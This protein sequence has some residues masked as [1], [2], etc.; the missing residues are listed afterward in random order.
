MGASEKIRWRRM[1]NEM[2][3]LHSEKELIEQTN[4]EAAK[5]FQEH[6]VRFAAQHGLD[7]K[8]LNKQ[9]EE[10]LEEV[11]G[12]D[13]PKISPENFPD[14]EDPPPGALVVC[15]Q[16]MEPETEYAEMQ[17]NTEVHDSFNKLFR[18]LAM[19]LHPDKMVASVT[20]EQG[21]ENLRLFHEAKEALDK[22]K[23]FV[24][25]DLAEKYGI[26]QSRN[27]KQQIRWM[28]KECERLD[29][30]IAQEKATYNYIFADCETESEKDNLIRRFIHQLFNIRV[31]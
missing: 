26:T 10:R 1:V 14:I 27:Y 13:R 18:R 22:R 5:D 19:K 4:K 9:H 23:Y 25:L 15:E 12:A 11:Y 17:D 16:P 31:E 29:A 20:I 7:L 6:Y 24:L 21:M 8:K 3:F 28:K 2:R 30:K